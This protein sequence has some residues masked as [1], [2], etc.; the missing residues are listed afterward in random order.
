MSMS[1]LDSETGKE[2]AKQIG[3]TL[4]DIIAQLK[5]HPISLF[6]IAVMLLAIV[7]LVVLA[8]V[9]DIPQLKWFPYAL[10]VFGLFMV[11]VPYFLTPKQDITK[12]SEIISTSGKPEMDVETFAST[13]QEVTSHNQKGGITAFNVNTTSDNTTDSNIPNK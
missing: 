5:E 12:E 3:Q 1:P 10:L 11:L 4:R 9:P 7:A 6:G 2:V 8:I 13:H